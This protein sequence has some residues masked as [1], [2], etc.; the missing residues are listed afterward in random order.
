MGNLDPADPLVK[1]AVLGKQVE[2]FVASDVG[3]YLISRIDCEVDEAVELLK[4]TYSWRT[5]RIR[6]LQNHIFRLESIKTWLVQAIATGH[7][8][9]RMIEDE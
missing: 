7:D 8:A 2:D 1:D 6:D 3:Q 5:R 9:L 4:K